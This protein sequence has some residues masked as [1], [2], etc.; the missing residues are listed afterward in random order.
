V[1]AI[2]DDDYDNVYV[3]TVPTIGKASVLRLKY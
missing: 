2:G 3:V 1:P